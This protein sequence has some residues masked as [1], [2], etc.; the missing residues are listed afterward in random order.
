MLRTGRDSGEG[1]QA[2]TP[3]WIRLRGHDVARSPGAG[4]SLIRAADDSRRHLICRLPSGNLIRFDLHQNIL[5]SRAR[6]STQRE[7]LNPY[8]HYATNSN[9]PEIACV[10]LILQPVQRQGK[11]RLPAVVTITEEL[12]SRAP[13]APAAIDFRRSWGLRN[14]ISCNSR[15]NCSLHDAGPGSVTP[16]LFKII[17]CDRR[18]NSMNHPFTESGAGR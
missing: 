11:M 5:P 17:P 10:I 13:R 7:Q 2:G 1:P 4:T 14:G 16:C 6:A 3:P 9:H 15:S 12:I 18:T 8:P